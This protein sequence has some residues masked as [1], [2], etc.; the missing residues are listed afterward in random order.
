MKKSI[1]LFSIL[2]FLFSCKDEE[3]KKRI[4]MQAIA[5]RQDQ[6][7]IQQKLDSMKILID[8]I[9]N[10]S[11]SNTISGLGSLYESCKKS[12]LILYTLD[13]NSQRLA[14]GS[15]FIIGD[16]GLGI[17]NYHVFENA[18]EVVAVD[19]EGNL[20]NVTEFLN[21]DIDL[22]YIY[23]RIPNY[24]LPVLTIAPSLPNIGDQCFAIGAPHGLHQT[25]STG[26]ISAYRNDQSV[27]QTSAEITHGSSGGPL[28]NAVGQ[29]I[30]ITSRGVGDANL[31]F[32]VNLLMLPRANMSYADNLSNLPIT[33]SFLME[34]D[35]SE[36]TNNDIKQLTY[37]YYNNLFNKE[38]N[39][40]WHQYA[41]I[42]KEFSN[43]NDVT[44]SFVISDHQSYYNRFT[45][46]HYEIID[47][48]YRENKIGSD[49]ESEVILELNIYRNSDRKR[50]SYRIKSKLIFNDE[51]KITSVK[52]DKI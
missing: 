39:L 22:D 8:S 10:S 21:Y 17:S 20:Y 52:E 33:N 34:D 28:F 47:N 3:I 5:A 42:I 25:L 23:F 40:L 51:G 37:D 44:R 15:A 18:K 19:Y 12:V 2:I 16:N 46:E 36:M 9:Q 4:D 24:N 45:V 48:S 1:Y 50:F 29:V 35:S 31:N 11:A 49:I 41:Y 38:W 6:I 30:G 27:I 32:A 26:I 43:H 14:Q 7:A 13:A